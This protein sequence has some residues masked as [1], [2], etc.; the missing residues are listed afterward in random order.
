MSEVKIIAVVMI[1]LYCHFML[2]AGCVGSMDKENVVVIGKDECSHVEVSM[3]KS[4]IVKLPVRLGTGFSWH[5]VKNEGGHIQ[6]EGDSRFE[7]ATGDHKFGGV[8]NQVLRFVTLNRGEEKLLLFYR[9]PFE[10]DG[11][12]KKIYE[13]KVQVR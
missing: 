7:S 4:L 6:Q 9:R 5:V 1:L 8:E 11:K 12:P 3:G 13:I 2:S 10:T